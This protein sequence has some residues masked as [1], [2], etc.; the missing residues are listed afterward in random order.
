MGKINVRPGTLLRWHAL[1]NI[2]KSK[3]K[4]GFVKLDN[5]SYDGFISTPSRN[6]KMINVLELL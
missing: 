3:I 1:E 2:L 4:D 6:R 5:G